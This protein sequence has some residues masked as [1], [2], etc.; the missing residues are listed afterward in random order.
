MFK[1][2]AQAVNGSRRNIRRNSKR[3]S[4]KNILILLPVFIVV[5]ILLTF[6]CFNILPSREEESTAELTAET[7]DQETIEQ[8]KEEIFEP[9]IDTKTLTVSSG[10]TLAELLVEGGLSK[11]LAHTVIASLKDVFNPR[12]LRKGQEI[13]LSFENLD[14]QAEPV[15]QC[16]SIK[17][18]VTK[19]VCVTRM[20]DNRFIS[21]E[22]IYELD[23][24]LSKARAEISSSLYNAAEKAGMPVD[25][26]VKLIRAYS[27]DVDFQRDI[28]PGD[29][30][31]A[32]YEKMVDKDG[33]YV[34][35]G[36]ILYALLKTKGV[37]L[38]VY[39][40]KTSDGHYDLYNEDGESIRKTLMV[41]PIDGARLSSGYGMRKHPVLGYSRMHK[42]LDFAAPRGTPIMAAGDG[43]IEY[44]GRKGGY[45][46]Y[47]CIRHANEY[48]T[49]YGHMSKY[50]SDIKK[51]VRV[52]QGQV[53]GYV[54][55]TGV[56][57]G[58]H[59]H[60]EVL[61]RNKSINPSSVKTP[62][63]KTLKDEELERFFLAK[64][65]LESRYVSLE[66]PKKIASLD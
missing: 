65:E 12:S 18:D 13:T 25:V 57:T 22:I 32:L 2:H 19:E 41:T 31:E 66:D 61:H 15:F 58:P 4:K 33:N 21:E 1:D 6:S 10:D 38:P 26:L 49:L 64:R 34:R 50:G 29:R 42:G 16:L 8:P 53:I 9:S 46:N 28:R 35:G 30:F 45:G 14:E 20:P 60:Y 47:I 24:V 52:K 63:G 62:P 59:L 43:I 11:T 40:F 7:A 51:G 39:R 23:A 56:S 54:G 5:L 17:L 3:H 55:S 27:Y 36:S 37:A 44:V 48:K